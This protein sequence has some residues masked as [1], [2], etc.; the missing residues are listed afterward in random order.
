MKVLVRKSVTGAEYW[1]TEEK[2]SVFV[3]KSV[4][5]DFEVDQN[6]KTMITAETQ[7][8]GKINSEIFSSISL[9]KVDKGKELIDHENENEVI[10]KGIN[11]P[12]DDLEIKTV[13]ELRALAKK[14]GID[15]PNAI[16]TKGDIINIIESS[17]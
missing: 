11:E 15:I 16:R 9:G 4:E 2:R 7:A 1:D 13:K 6:P 14:E 8:A 12:K 3:P 5:P 17:K 10:T